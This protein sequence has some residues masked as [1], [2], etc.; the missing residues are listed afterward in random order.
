MKAN[1]LL[2]AII[3]SLMVMTGIFLIGYFGYHY[4]DTIIV[5]IAVTIFFVFAWYFYTKGQED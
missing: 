3:K 1:K 4:P 5:A 2:L